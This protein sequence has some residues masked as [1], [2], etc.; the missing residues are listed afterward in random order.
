MHAFFSSL[1]LELHF[2]VQFQYQNWDFQFHIYHQFDL[3]FHLFQVLMELLLANMDVFWLWIA[4][5][6]FLDV[7]IGILAIQIIQISVQVFFVSFLNKFQFF[8]CQFWCEETQNF[9]F[10]HFFLISKIDKEFLQII[11]N[12]SYIL[13]AY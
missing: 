1:Y 10:L 8:I 12:G 2:Q 3:Y 4:F 9:F 11:I 13:Y 5:F 6:H 7:N